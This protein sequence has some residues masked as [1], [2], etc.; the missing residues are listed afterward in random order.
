MKTPKLYQKNIKN[1]VITSDMLSDCLYS[2]NKRAKNCRDQARNYNHSA[3]R[4]ADYY[5]SGYVDS[6]EKYYDIKEKLLQLL[7]P[8]C[9]HH[10]IYYQYTK[11]RI[12]DYQK[13]FQKELN[14]AQENDTFI[15]F[16]RYYDYEEEKEVYFFDRKTSEKP[17]DYYYLFYE[18]KNHSYHTPIEKEDLV[19]YPDIP[20]V[21]LDEN[22]VTTGKDSNELISVSFVN[23][24]L[25]LI[26]SGDFKY[27]DEQTIDN[28]R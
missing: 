5:Y 21:D 12:Y 23:K 16:G 6:M 20:I 18:L 8:V 2:V 1:R 24:V 13:K 10:E 14:K 25:D 15:K 9:I 4:Y 26:K 28:D 11:E 17:V 22:I 19:K 3:Y 7:N 27:I